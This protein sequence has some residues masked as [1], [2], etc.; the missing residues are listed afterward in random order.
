MIPIL[1]IELKNKEIQQIR[2]EVWT[3]MNEKTTVS[4]VYFELNKKRM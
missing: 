3:K 1:D 2:K 4:M